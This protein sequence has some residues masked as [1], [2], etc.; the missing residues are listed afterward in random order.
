LNRQA[1]QLS[2][3]PQGYKFR[4]N[5][6]AAQLELI[7]RILLTGATGQT[8]SELTPEEI[9]AEPRFLMWR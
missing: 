5:R 1:A 7:Q 4:L 9:E 8:G 6:Q 3:I 2:F